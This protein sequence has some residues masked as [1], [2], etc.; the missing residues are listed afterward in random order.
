MY[1]YIQLDEKL[2]LIPI[3]DTRSDDLFQ[4]PYEGLIQVRKVWKIA[5]GS[6]R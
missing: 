4:E 2:P 1:F 6:V 5:D 3:P